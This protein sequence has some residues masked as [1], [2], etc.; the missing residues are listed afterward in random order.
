MTNGILL[1]LDIGNV[2]LL[3]LLDLSSAFDTVDQDCLFYRL[4]SLC[5]ISGTVLLWL[6][7]LTG[8]RL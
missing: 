7:S 3:I 4:Q 5:G 8:L 2:S 6:E 1:A